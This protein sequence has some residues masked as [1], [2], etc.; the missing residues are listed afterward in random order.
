MIEK[1]VDKILRQYI[2]PD[3]SPNEYVPDELNMLI[4]EMKSVFPQLTTLSVDDI[5]NFRYNDMSNHLKNLTKMA[6]KN[7]EKITIDNFNS[8]IDRYELNEERQEAFSDDNVIRQ[9]ERDILLQVI[10]AKWIDHLANIDD[11]KDS[12]GLVAYGQKDPL[13][14]Y[15]KGAF[16]LFNSMMSEIQSE[17]VRHLMRTKFGVQ[18]MGADN[19]E[20][21]DLALSDAPIAP[22]EAALAAFGQNREIETEL[23]KALKNSTNNEAEI[24]DNIDGTESVNKNTQIRNEDKIGRNDKCPC[25]SGQ[26][27]KNCCGKDL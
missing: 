2:S 22:P 11:L 10:D 23:T 18:I 21:A 25:G 14:E 20:V 9:L 15:K 13:L 6:Y 7:H 27:Y 16:N 8:V 26:K 12:I 3:M 19:N 4:N 5:K 24:S 1:E 17:T